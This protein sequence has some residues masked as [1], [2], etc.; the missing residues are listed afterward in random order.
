[1]DVNVLV[2]G[3]VVGRPGRDALKR[4]LKT[5][6]RDRKVDFVVANGENAAGG[7]GITPETADDLF[8]A[9]VDVITTGDHAWDKKEIVP[10][11]E[12]QTKLLRPFNFPE[13]AAG[14]GW[15]VAESASGVKVAVCSLLGRVF[16]NQPVDNPFAAADRFLK[17]VEGQARVTVIDLHAE[18][19]SEKVALGWHV[20]GRASLVVG[21]HTHIPTADE[22]VYPNGTA[23]ITDLGMTGPYQSVLGRRHDRVLQRFVTG[24]PSVYD[25]AE[26]DVRIC[27]VLAVVDDKTGCAKHIE[28]VCI[29]DEG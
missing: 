25:V 18:A 14:R 10:Y 4:H 20:D 28:R 11:I 19:T 2:L 24:M 7:A 12:R 9:G 27:G 5:V 29:R 17:A 8:A 13:E 15:V 1:M 21:T 26:G 16:L 6:R 23:Y 22:H 3:D